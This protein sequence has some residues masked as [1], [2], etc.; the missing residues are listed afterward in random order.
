MDHLIEISE[1]HKRLRCKQRRVFSPFYCWGI[2]LSV[3]KSFPLLWRSLEG[4]SRV[5]L[6]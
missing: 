3:K 4:I 2:S 6:W 1:V 5:S